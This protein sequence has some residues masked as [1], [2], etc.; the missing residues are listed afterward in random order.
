MVELRYI[1]FYILILILILQVYFI[2][3]YNIFKADNN[4]GN[5]KIY[6]MI[7]LSDLYPYLKTGDLLFFSFNDADIKT[8]TFVNDRISHIAMIYENNGKLFTLEMNSI[9][10]ISS[11][12]NNLYKN[13]NIISLDK[14]IE[15]YSGTIYYAS[16]LKELTMN[17]KNILNNIIMDAQNYTYT[18][19]YKLFFNFLFHS[20]KL[21]NKNRFCT[22]LIA[23]ILHKLNISSVPYNS[24]KI[25]LTNNILDLTDNVIYTN[26]ILILVDKLIVKDI[27]DSEYIT[28][29]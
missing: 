9:D 7:K 13:F 22:E 5:D 14:R 3:I 10:F 19:Q 21:D 2:I 8:R 20:Y 4:K 1:I 29:C 25:N 6:K 24:S 18:G 15:N 17:Q 12:D 16:L 27:K 11:D 26:R 23:E 28:Y